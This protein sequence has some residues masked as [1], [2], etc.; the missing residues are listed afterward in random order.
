MKVN[1][2]PVPCSRVWIALLLVFVSFCCFAQQ[3]VTHSASPVALDRSAFI[4]AWKLIRID[5]TGSKGIMKDPYFG[6][7]Q[8]GLI[9][10]DVSGWMS[11]QIMTSGRPVLPQRSS[12][13]TAM[14]NTQHDAQVKA[15]AMDSYYAYFGTWT[16]DVGKQIVTHHRTGSLF[17]YET[18][19][20][21]VR[22]A[23]YDGQ[24]LN[25]VVRESVDGEPRTRTLVWERLPVAGSFIG[26][27]QTDK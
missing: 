19:T 4:G 26:N 7:G 18:G 21:A 25:L 8:E 3:E 20:D 15:A 14:K 13:R 5:Y 16:F 24:Y 23:K 27:R 22:E 2:G 6:V 11:V 1:L 17:S 10:Y 9:L 12:T